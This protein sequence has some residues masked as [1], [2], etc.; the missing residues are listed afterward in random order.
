MS[1]LS[2]YDGRKPEPPYTTENEEALKESIEL[3]R[4]LS[5]ELLKMRL[6][7]DPD[8]KKRIKC[9]EL[10]DRVLDFISNN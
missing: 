10:T 2:L 5:T 4:E 1:N 6:D 7:Y 8:D 3:L 9:E